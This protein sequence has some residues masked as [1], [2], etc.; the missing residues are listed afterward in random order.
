MDHNARVITRLQR[1]QWRAVSSETMNVKERS[2]SEYFSSIKYF[3]LHRQLEGLSSSA[4]ELPGCPAEFSRYYV[5]KPELSGEPDANYPPL[6]VWS[7]RSSR[8][9]DA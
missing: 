3:R 6:L 1:I 4:R 7:E 8:L 9:I 2:D 5:N